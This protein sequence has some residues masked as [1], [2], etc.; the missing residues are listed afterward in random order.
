MYRYTKIAAAG[1]VLSLAAAAAYSASQ[2]A[3][4]DYAAING[5]KITLSQ[6]IGTAEQ[7]VQGKAT[8]AEL[9]RSKGTIVFDVEVVTG[10]KTFDV[11]I[12]PDKGTVLAATEDKSD[13]EDSNDQED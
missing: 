6:A 9:E 12:D 8:R 10:T 13:H 3:E 11:K 1:V 2:P 5:A 7:H 4:N